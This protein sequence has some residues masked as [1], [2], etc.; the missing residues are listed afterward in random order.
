MRTTVDEALAEFQ[1]IDG[2]GNLSE[3]KACAMTLLAWLDECDEWTDHPR[4]CHSIIA[5]QVIMANDAPRTTVEDRAQ[6]V[7][8]GLDGALD[9]WW[10]PNE[11]IAFA[12]RAEKDADPPTTLQRAVMLLERIV[13]WKEDKQRPDLR[14]ADLRG[15]DLRSANLRSAD[16][17][18]ADLGGANLGSADLGSADLR[19]AN[20]RSAD[21]GSADLRGANLGSANLGSADLGGAD[22][23]G[24]DLR[25]AN[26]GSA[27]LGGADLRGANLG[28]ADLGSADLRSANLR[29]AYYSQYT[30]WPEGVDPAER[31][32]IKV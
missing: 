21:L 2:P 12:M 29:G 6:L 16:L 19:S 26:L 5:S 4:C 18:S 25:G 28:S 7:R 9:T 3:K 17:G 22:L 31:G 8:L 14:S 11:V 1:L 32:A 13:A 20:L 15:A 27:N 23:G 10:I 30:T 24:A